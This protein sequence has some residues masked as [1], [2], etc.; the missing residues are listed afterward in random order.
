MITIE[1]VVNHEGFQML[2]D[3][4]HKQEANP[5]LVGGLVRRGWT[6]HD[7]DIEVSK[8]GL[9]V[10]LELMCLKFGRKGWLPVSI[11]VGGEG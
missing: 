8:L 4:L 6:G 2:M 3:I 1:E 7:I 9:K 5:K 11:D 10:P